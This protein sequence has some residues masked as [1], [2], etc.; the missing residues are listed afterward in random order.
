MSRTPDELVA[1]AQLFLLN[2]GRARGLDMIFQ[3]DPLFKKFMIEECGLTEEAV[4]NVSKAAAQAASTL[5]D[6]NGIITPENCE[7][8][9]AVNSTSNTVV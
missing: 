7:K 3:M 9:L 6:Q 8:F 4:L 1:Q 2:I 5:T